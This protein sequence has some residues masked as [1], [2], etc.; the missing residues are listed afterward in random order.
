M[1]ITLLLKN[2]MDQ[3][4]NFPP[5]LPRIYVFRFIIRFAFMFYDVKPMGGDIPN[6]RGQS[7]TP[8]SPRSLL[9]F[10]NAT[11]EMYPTHKNF[12]TLQ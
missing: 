9:Y 1:K 6:T 12:C 10:E 2:E 4:K 3:C 5:M 8:P 11:L 7:W